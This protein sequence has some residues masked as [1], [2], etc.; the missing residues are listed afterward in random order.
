M[1]NI[2]KFYRAR[3]SKHNSV[4]LPAPFD[5]ELPRN[6]I[7]GN[8]AFSHTVS[9]IP[10]KQ[11]KTTKLK[12]PGRWVRIGNLNG[13]FGL[14]RKVSKK[15]LEGQ[16]AVPAIEPEIRSRRNRSRNTYFPQEMV[17]DL[18][19]LINI[20]PPFFVGRGGDSGG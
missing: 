14:D 1:R 19:K 13:I 18:A 17:S 12:H 15:S 3:I 16:A 20:A 9:E 5:D 7:M 8:G 6:A 10:S 2:L 4:E 11:E